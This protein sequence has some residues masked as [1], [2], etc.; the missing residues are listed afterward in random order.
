MIL[1][2]ASCC[3]FCL[4]SLPFLRCAVAAAL[5]GFVR[6]FR[7][8]VVWRNTQDMCLSSALPDTPVQVSS[9]RWQLRYNWVS[10]GAALSV[11]SVRVNIYPWQCRDKQVYPSSPWPGKYRAA[12]MGC[13]AQEKLPCVLM[14]AWGCQGISFLQCRVPEDP[15]G[16]LSRNYVRRHFP[17]HLLHRLTGC[18]H[19][20]HVEFL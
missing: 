9:L 8:S 15:A 5:R 10:Q 2:A 13:H 17:V 19:L 3:C 20:K 4:S 7:A 18:C 14:P 6:A 16:D 1:L 11:S 12:P